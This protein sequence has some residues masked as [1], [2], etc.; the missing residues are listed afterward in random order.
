[1]SAEV[2]ALDRNGERY[3][4]PE[5]AVELARLGDH[6]IHSAENLPAFEPFEPYVE[7]PDDEHATGKLKKGQFRGYASVFDVMVETFMPTVIHAGSFAESLREVKEGRGLLPLFYNHNPDW[8]IGHSVELHEDDKGM[9]I[10]GQIVPYGKG[11]DTLGFIRTRVL[12]ANSIG[13][14]AVRFEFE[15][16]DE[17]G[18]LVRH[19][20][21]FR[22]KEVS[23]VAFPAN[24]PS[25]ITEVNSTPIQTNSAVEPAAEEAERLAIARAAHDETRL[26]VLRA[27]RLTR[28]NE[29][30]AATAAMLD[31]FGA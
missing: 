3:Q 12:N 18:D 23:V 21:G 14:W 4:V 26:A 1:M 11:P 5:R 2:F 10:V 8:P 24:K 30:D 13:G 20:Y 7:P 25:L 16:D 22:L 28:R 19:V 6:E 31:A 27:E 17:I 29:I 15:E 9:Q